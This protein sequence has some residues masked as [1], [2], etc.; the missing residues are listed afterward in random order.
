MTASN[1]PP[2]SLSWLRPTASTDSARP[3]RKAATAAASCTVT[4]ST[5]PPPT[6]SSSRHPASRCG[7][8][9]AWCTRTARTSPTSPSR[10]A[11]LTARW[12]GEA[13]RWWFVAITTPAA[14]QAGH[15]RA[16][17]LEGQRERL[18]GEHVLARGG[19]RLDVLAVLRVDGG[20]VHRVDVVAVHRRHRGRVTASGTRAPSA[21]RAACSAVA[22]P[23][24]HRRVAQR[25]GSRAAPWWQRCRWRRRAPTAG[26]GS[27]SA[28][29]HRGAAVRRGGWL[30]AVA[31]LSADV[32][33][34]GSG[35]GGA[36][37]ALALARRGVDVLVLERGRAPAPRA[38][39]LVAT[40][41]LRRAA[42]QAGRDL[43]RRP[44]PAVRAR[45]STTSWAAAPR[46]TAPAC[47]ASG[48][49]TSAR[50]STTRAPRPRGRSAMPTSS[51]TTPRP[52]ASTGCTAT[53]AEDPTEPWRS[54]PYP[55]PAL[56]HEPYVAD[57]AERLRAQGVHPSANA[58]GV[59]RGPSGGC[60]RCATCDGFPCR[61]G[62]KSDAETCA[63]DPALAGTGLAAG[64][65]EPGAAGSSRTAPAAGSTTWSPMAPTGRPPSGA[66]GSCW[67]PA[68]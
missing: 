25:P 14:R 19:G 9:T 4:S 68:P 13:G 52:S 5:T 18:L 54:S 66:A 31:D 36:T 16:R 67:P 34:I 17:V 26:V 39:Q 62:A 32:V 41:G 21:Q 65:R 27:C 49:T 48:S 57:L 60:I 38:G 45:A 20:H 30:A 43:V 64:D 63:I 8:C 61:L 51:P 46:S 23:H 6:G 2:G 12:V 58:M 42:V 56:E 40:R 55:H 11:R 24:H 33:V 44:R 7:S 28:V 50:S 37:T 35:M 1:G 47:R 3:P 10:T 59:D 22:G 15:H 29:K 53:P